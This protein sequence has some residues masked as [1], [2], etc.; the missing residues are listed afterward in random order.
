MRQSQL[1][2]STK[3]D[4]SKEEVSKNAIL[5][6]RGGYIDKEMAGVYTLLPL[7]F[8]MAEK[9]KNI[10]REELNK[11][12][13]TSEVLM[14]VMQ[15]HKLW[16]ATGRRE[17]IKDVMYDIKDE[18]I[19]LGPTHE[20]VATELFSHFYNSYKQMPVAIYQMQTKFRNE[21]RAKSGLLRGRE[22]MMKD[23]YSFHLTD[24]DI[25]EYYK[26]VKDA[27]MRIFDRVGLQAIYTD[28]SGGVFTK[29]R[30]HE[31]QVLAES[32]EDE[33]YL[34]QS[35]DRAWNKE[36]VN[37]SDPEFLQF[38][39]GVI[40][41]RSA[42]EVGN[43]FRFDNKYS[44]PLNAAI[45]NKNGERVEVLGASYGIG[46]TRLIGTIAEIYGDMEKSKINW[47][48]SV[49]PY[50]I[51]LIELGLGLGAELYN[52][53]VQ[54]DLLYDDRDETAGTKFADADLIGAPTRI[55]ISSRTLEKDSV[56]LNGELVK[57]TDLKNKLT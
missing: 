7:A 6:T 52:Q 16:E 9:I 40:D 23:L 35:G 28:A 14:P 30:S 55:I 46:I 18:S 10:I 29:Y 5:L 21:P 45:T 26:Q 32:G 39:E 50:K 53:L 47:P 34:N 8:R 12:P 49:A 56:E 51:H 42:I 25:A 37:E 33:I 19:G 27:Y 44:S 36:L 11:L 15:P 24:E 41:K 13:H 31:F 2:G 43:I 20:E 38:C 54:F 22:F 48:K 17:I 3:R 4:I 57:L 1:F